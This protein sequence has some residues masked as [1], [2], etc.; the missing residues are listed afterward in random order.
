M[1]RCAR[2]AAVGVNKMKRLPSK[3]VG[4][5]QT[6]PLPFPGVG[7]EAAEP[8]PSPEAE[9]VFRSPKRG[10]EP[11]AHSIETASITVSSRSRGQI[12]APRPSVDPA[13]GR[14]GVP[15]GR[16]RGRP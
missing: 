9:K 3:E 2:R 10:G 6:G 7:I 15:E 8:F 11:F 12:C 13:R 5:R 14:G 1:R 16:S 4:I